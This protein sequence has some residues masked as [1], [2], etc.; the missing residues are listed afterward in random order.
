M[1][2]ER[3]RSRLRKR[4][5]EGIDFA[6]PPAAL[7]GGFDTAIFAFRLTG[8]P[9]DWSGELI[10]RVMPFAGS[11][12]R[13]RREAA[14]HA[15]LVEAGF[16][17]PRILLAE[18]DEAALGK[19]FLIME[20]LPG[21]TMWEAIVGK[22]G[23]LARLVAL[24]GQLAEIHAR[25]HR[26]KGEALLASARAHAVDRNLVTLAGEVRRLRR[27][28]DEAGLGGLRRGADWLERNMPAPAEPEVICH[29]D[30]HPLNVMVK[31]DRVTGVI[32][33]AQAIVAEPA[34]DVGATRVLGRFADPHLPRWAHGPIGIA[35]QLILRRYR[36]VYR[37]LRPFEERNVP[38]FEAV[39]VLSALTF[40]GERPGPG[41]PWGAPHTVAVLTQ[42]F[43]RI[44]G[45][46]V[47]I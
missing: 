41:N 39:R 19:P 36:Q 28:I 33:W 44:S 10:L 40:A 3:L 2:A 9:A 13:V 43:E 37:T 18:T 25:M 47:H 32:D 30:F 22:D 8:A 6:A 31:D 4:L 20:R 34:Y 7:S 38:Y 15:A 46:A 5:G 29:G 45:V 23:R 26:V 12:M 21:R 35:R 1:I 27:R 16:P 17:A 11:A 14:T 42:A 24:P